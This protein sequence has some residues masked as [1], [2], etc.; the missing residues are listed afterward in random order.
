MGSRVGALCAGYG[1][2]ELGLSKVIDTKLS[3]VSE[4][5]TNANYLLEKRFNVP[6]YGD[7]TKLK[8]NELPQI[9]ICTAGFPCTPFSQAGQELGVH[10]SRWLIDDVC[11]IA[12]LAGAK[13]LILENVSRI[14]TTNN[15][16]ALARV[17]A[18]MAYNG[19]SRWEWTTLPASAAKAPHTRKRWF[20]VATNPDIR[21]G[22]KL[23]FRDGDWDRS[24]AGFYWTPKSEF[25]RF[26]FSGS[27]FERY[28]PAI[29]RWEET[30]RRPAPEPYQEYR[31]NHWF[32]EWMMGLPHGWVCGDDLG[33]SRSACLRL[34]G[35]G[36]VPQQA[37]M[38]ISILLSRL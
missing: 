11:K 33:F 31:L 20:C 23:N 3:W 14:L 36:V 37:A 34:L 19:F 32:V 10:D 15:G 18:A 38:A 5:E 21:T 1:G 4:I 17:C 6:N 22:Q 29:R 16:E 13:W 30:I 9:D 24:Q 8:G 26:N 12:R 25:K 28:E 7:L 27:A 2:V 35:N